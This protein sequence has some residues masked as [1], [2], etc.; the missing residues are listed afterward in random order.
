MKIANLIHP[1]DLGG[2]LFVPASHKNLLNTAAGTKF[3][4]LR[5]MVIDFEDGLDED[6]IDKGFTQLK[7]LLL[8]PKPKKLLRFIRPKNPKILEK[9]YKLDNIKNIDGFILPKFGL[10]NANTYL[11]IIQRQKPEGPYTFMPSIEGEELF[12]ITKLQKLKALL[13]PYKKD[14]IL[15]RFGAE[16]MMQQLGLR[17]RCDTSLFDMSASC[18]VLGN[19]ISCFKPEGFEISGAV[20]H[21]FQDEKGF[22]EDIARDIKEGF[23]TKTIIHPNQI[24]TLNQAYRVTQEDVSEAEKIMGTTLSVFNLE[25]TMGE[26]STMTPWAQTILK[27]ATLYGII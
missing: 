8:A 17:R 24:T 26:K 23:C 3:E 16:D 9:L 5:S 22:K 19:L 14:I 25:G 20:Y 10:K 15:I 2:T 6:K 27:R 7:K 18:N 11:N 1:L 21:C 12:D 4:A 13:L